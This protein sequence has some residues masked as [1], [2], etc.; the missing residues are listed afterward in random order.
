M[1]LKNWKQSRKRG[2]TYWEIVH[3]LSKWKLHFDWK[4]KAKPRRDFSLNGEMNIEKPIDYVRSALC[5]VVR[6]AALVECR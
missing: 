6:L 1:Y 4:K 5:T 2:E 3:T